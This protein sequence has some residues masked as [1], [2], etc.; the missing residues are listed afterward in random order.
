MV[1]GKN[2]APGYEASK[3]TRIR[4]IQFFVFANEQLTILTC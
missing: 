3:R 4:A 2:R 1:I